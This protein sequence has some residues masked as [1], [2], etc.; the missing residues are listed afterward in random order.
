MERKI[1]LNLLEWK[2]SPDRKP[3]IL[4]GARQ[5][6]KTYTTLSFGKQHY[7]SCVYFN[8]ENNSEL[9][10]IFERDLEP[11][12]IVMELSAKSGQS[13]LKRETL[14]FFDEIQ[15]CERA[16][17]SLKYFNEN[18]NDYH[19]IAAGSL[20]GVAVNREKYSFPVGKVDFINMYPLDFEEFLIALGQENLVNAIKDCFYT[21]T[22]LSIHETAMDY[23]RKYLLTGG[24]PSVIVQYIDKQDFDFVKAEQ[25][26]IN[27]A[28]IA[29]M[30]KYATPHETTKIMA[31][32]ESIPAQLAKENKKFQYKVIKTGAK[33]NQYET[34]IDWLKSSGI[35]IKCHK[36]TEGNLPLKAYCDFS[37]FKL[38][39]TDIGLLTSKFDIPANIILSGN[40][41]FDRFK[42]ALAENYAAQALVTNGH[43]IFY[44]ESS[45]K[46]ELDFVMQDKDG[47]II[48]IEVK[49]GEH[50]K[51]KSLGVFC[52]KYQCD[53]SIRISGKNFGFEN[54]IKSVPL[55]AVWL[56]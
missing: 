5:V 21:N 49:S 29:D 2:N 34:P 14:I 19:I 24:M 35:I 4:Q 47:N 33:A 11:E 10:Q 27:D 54:G 45:G 56:I 25:K 31:A 17:S 3:L 39:L 52:S 15:A 40:I 30:A 26:N 38:Y 18:A 48:P 46:A 44:W 6:G 28:Y 9:A 36:V 23:Y 12:R 41:H 51:A 42:G 22:P 37:S 8:F 13:I 43:N 20:L 7:K 16:L 32:F 1:E 50:T 55:Y 53:Y